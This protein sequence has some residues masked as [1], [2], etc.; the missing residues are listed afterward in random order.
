MTI[1]INQVY[2]ADGPMAGRTII[3]RAIVSEF[4]Y[5][6]ASNGITEYGAPSA[7]PVREG[8]FRYIKT[9]ELRDGVPVFRLAPIAP[10]S[11]NQ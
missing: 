10:A 4:D 2:V 6:P 9:A 7:Q 8:R 3:L 5:H 11:A 1:R